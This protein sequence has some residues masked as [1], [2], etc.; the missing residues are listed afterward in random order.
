MLSGLT[1]DGYDRY[2]YN[3][4][5]YDSDYCQY[6]FNGPFV[7]QQSLHVW[8]IL[9]TQPHIFLMT[10]TKTCEPLQRLPNSWYKKF[11]VQPPNTAVM[12]E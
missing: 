9:H 3:I 2:G 10:L 8:E 4:D 12:G 6:S 11:W 1:R 7:T 5:G